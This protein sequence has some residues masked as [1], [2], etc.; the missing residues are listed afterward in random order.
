MPGKWHN[1]W[2]SYFDNKEE[3][4]YNAMFTTPSKTRRADVLLNNYVIEF[5]HSQISEQEIE[6]R[7]KDWSCENKK[8]FWVIDGNDTCE[9]EEKNGDSN[10]IT[11]DLGWWKANNFKCYDIVFFDIGEKIYTIEPKH[12]KSNVVQVSIPL[13]KREF[14]EMLK[15]DNMEVI[16]KLNY[17]YIDHRPTIH[18]KQEGAG[19]GK[20][21]GIIQLL[22][23]DK[24][25]HYDTF[26]YLT[27]QHSAVNVIKQE[28]NDQIKRGEL[29]NIE[30]KHD[31]IDNKKHI[32]KYNNNKTNN[33]E[34]KKIIIGTID[35]FK[36]ALGDKTITGIDKFRTLVN[37]I[38]DKDIRAGK[39]G[40]ISYTSTGVKLNMK[41]LIIGD[42]MQDLHPE[43]TKALVKIAKEK[44][45]DF[46]AVGDK[47]QS[48]S[49]EKNAFTY[50]TDELID[51]DTI[52]VTKYQSKNIC[53]RF[54]DEKLITFVN[55]CVPFGKYGLPCIE[56]G[57]KETDAKTIE[58]FNGGRIDTNKPLQ[59]DIN[60]EADNIMEKYEYEVNKYDRS[61]KDFLIVTPFVSKNPLLDEVNSKI[62]EFWRKKY[63][64]DDTYVKYSIF[65]KSEEGTSIDLTQSLESTRIVSIHS[66][67]GDGRPVVFVIGLTES[68]LLKYTSSNDSL[69]FN[70]LLHVA[71]TRQKEK[72]YFR[73]ENQGDKINELIEKYLEKSDEYIEP[74]FDKSKNIKLSKLLLHNR[75]ENFNI[76]SD[77]IISKKNLDGPIESS[78]GPNMLIDMQ[79]H[80][81]RYNTF[82]I[83]IRLYLLSN[84]IKLNETPYDEPI[85]QVLKKLQKIKV[86]DV[87][88]C[89]YYNF[90]RN[91]HPKKKGLFPVIKLSKGKYKQYYD[92]FTELI[93]KV[94]TFITYFLKTGNI[95]DSYPE[96]IDMVCLYY[97]MEIYDNG[98][99]SNISIDDMYDIIDIYISCSGKDKDIYLENHYEK[100]SKTRQ[101]VAR[102]TEENPNLTYLLNYK[103]NYNGNTEDFSIFH[104]FELI[105]YNETDVVILE[106]KP[107]FNSL[108]FNDVLYDSIFKTFLINNS[109]HNVSTNNIKLLNKNIKTAVLTYDNDLKPYYIEWEK[110]I[111]TNNDILLDA[112]KKNMITHFELEHNK[113]YKYFLYHKSKSI[114]GTFI[115]RLIREYKTKKS[116][117]VCYNYV[118]SFLSV[119]EDKIE[120]EGIETITKEYYMKKLHTKLVKS[121]NQYII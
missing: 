74:I 90:I 28:L 72:L 87:D 76:I 100:I 32:I 65:H 57:A 119:I 81:I 55:N 16:D 33:E 49:N 112:Y 22:E 36:W 14:I 43:Y 42:E 93:E 61:P 75:L 111:D 84:R 69:I 20:T 104:K 86:V 101:I 23:N 29:P 108:N 5:Q 6:K 98:L 13:L 79:H 46:Y 3:T 1:E 31:N 121:V 52:R 35:S 2:Q 10:I 105:G 24:Y 40:Y 109:K 34:E 64:D 68:A 73:Y 117:H 82:S 47:L 51:D 17:R 27:K 94:K 58:F 88:I 45:V 54:R 9:V 39:D 115:E 92:F 118:L 26:V 4:V 63:N 107:Q 113:L 44:Y 114:N 21:Y 70:S 38:I 80:I 102:F 60:K 110:S 120:E 19:N 103:V 71:I 97:L 50:L 8:I 41:T 18:I 89:E 96:W 106:I 77:N 66:S 95:S 78:N 85:Y 30:I 116:K 48:I 99:Y 12:I 62:R 67:K 91:N 56:N 37:D 15:Q 59:D 11:V 25:Q 7:M 83:L 53:R